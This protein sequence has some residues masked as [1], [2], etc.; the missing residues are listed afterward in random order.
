MADRRSSQPASQQ[1]RQVTAADSEQG[2]GDIL[3]SMAGPVSRY[4]LNL[5]AYVSAGTILICLKVCF[6]TAWC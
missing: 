2:P 1:A 6:P 4:W 3:T 5:L